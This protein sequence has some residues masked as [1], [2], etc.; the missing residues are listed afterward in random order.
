[1][2]TQRRGIGQSI[3]YGNSANETVTPANETIYLFIK[4]MLETGWKLISGS[5][6]GIPK[7]RIYAKPQTK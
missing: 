1:M 4:A 6:T 3:W 2:H 7:Y 5:K